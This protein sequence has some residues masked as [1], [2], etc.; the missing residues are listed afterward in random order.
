MSDSCESTDTP[1]YY[2][3]PVSARCEKVEVACTGGDVNNFETELECAESCV[4]GKLS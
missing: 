3:D 1:R 2:F 4:G